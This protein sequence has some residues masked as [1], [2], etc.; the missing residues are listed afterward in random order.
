MSLTDD[1]Y[2]IDPA[3]DGE[4]GLELAEIT[5]YDAIILDVML[6]MKDGLEVCRELRNQRVKTPIIMLTARDTV[7]DRVLGLDSGADDYLIKPFALEELRGRPDIGPGYPFRRACRAI[8]PTYGERV[9]VAGIL[10]A[11]PEP[12]DHK[13][14]GRKP[15][16]EL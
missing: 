15:Y 1:G 5:P 12:G 10:H 13:G 7:E 4:E 9:L 8:H 16:L 2:A 6:P 11:K 14:D 3:F